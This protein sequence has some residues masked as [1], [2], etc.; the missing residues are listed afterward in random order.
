MR[1]SLVRTVAPAQPRRPFSAPSTFPAMTTQTEDTSPS[2]DREKISGMIG[3]DVGRSLTGIADEIDLTT[4]E[5][6]LRQALDG[7][8]PELSGE[9]QRGLGAAL[10][11]KLNGTAAGAA[12]T[13]ALPKDKVGLLIGADVGRALFSIRDELELGVFVQSVRAELG[14]GPSVMSDVEATAVREAFTRRMQAEVEA[15][16]Q[17][18]GAANAAEGAA[19]LEQNR[20]AEGVHITDSGLQ[21]Q[22]LQEGTGARPTAT[23]RVEVHYRGTSLDGT[24]FDSSYSRGAPTTFGLSQVVAGWTEGIA[25]MPVGAKF[26]FWIPAALGYGEAG[27][28]PVIGPNATLVFEVELLS[29]L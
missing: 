26:R 11:Q 1:A 28:P 10:A 4:F 12:D 9:E 7:G 5:R 16:G 22:V 20:A 6:A 23:S 24:E 18:A 15:Q 13:A 2:S 19:F 25:L 17:V 27:A 14:G 21:Y 8:V 29:V 3:I